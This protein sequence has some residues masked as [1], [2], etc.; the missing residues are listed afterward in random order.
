MKKDDPVYLDHINTS[1]GKPQKKMFLI[2]KD[3]CKKWKTTEVFKTTSH[4]KN[5]LR[6]LSHSKVTIPKL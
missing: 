6:C 2:S 1:L 3:V 4:Q 5:I